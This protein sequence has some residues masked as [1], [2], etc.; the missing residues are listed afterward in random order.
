MGGLGYMVEDSGFWVAG[1]KS[2][3]AYARFG[4]GEAGISGGSTDWSM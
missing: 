2:E 3:K 1:V 4:V